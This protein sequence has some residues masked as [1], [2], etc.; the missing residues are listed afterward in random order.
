MDIS[1]NSVLVELS[2]PEDKLEAFID[3]ARPYGI[4]ELARTGLVRSG[5]TG[6]LA[7][8]ILA[9]IRQDLAVLPICNEDGLVVGLV[10]P[11]DLLA[12]LGRALGVS[13]PEGARRE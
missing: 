3:L 6:G 7:E 5:E 8:L 1:H 2:G 9:S 4:Q 10:E 11:G 13:V 12:E